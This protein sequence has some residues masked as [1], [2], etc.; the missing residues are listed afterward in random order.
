MEKNSVARSEPATRNLLDVLQEYIE[1]EVKNSITKLLSEGHIMLPQMTNT[2][3]PLNDKIPVKEASQFTGWSEQT[4]YIKSSNGS[5][6]SYK[7]HGRLL[8]SRSE[9]SE[10]IEAGKKKFTARVAKSKKRSA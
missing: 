2:I 4:L 7:A 5:L 9:L 3:Q 6:P 10:I 8:F 1:G